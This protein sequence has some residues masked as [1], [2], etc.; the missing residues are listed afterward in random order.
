MFVSM[1]ALL[2]DIRNY[3]QQDR[4]DAREIITAADLP[5]GLTLRLVDPAKL[6]AEAH[7]ADLSVGR[8]SEWQWRAAEGRHC[9]AF[10]NPLALLLGRGDCRVG[11]WDDSLSQAVSQLRH[12]RSRIDRP[13]R[14]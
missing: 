10:R 2:R 6:D 4:V 12:C 9:T 8:L 5:C 13:I 11:P 1:A 14:L 7:L 3:T